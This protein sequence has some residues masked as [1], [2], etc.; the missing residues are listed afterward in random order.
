MDNLLQVRKFVQVQ[1]HPLIYSPHPPPA[2]AA[3]GGTMPM[4][5]A[6]AQ[7]TVHYGCILSWP[8]A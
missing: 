4:H 8:H 7:L 5:M 6:C 2:W 3:G 1:S